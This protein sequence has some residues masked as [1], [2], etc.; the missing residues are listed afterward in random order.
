MMTPPRLLALVLAA[1]RAAPP[2]ICFHNQHKS[3]GVTF[4]TAAWNT[5]TLASGLSRSAW[6]FERGRWECEWR[7]WNASSKACEYSLWLATQRKRARPEIAPTV[8]YGGFAPGAAELR[9]FARDRCVWL[10]VFR[11]PLARLVSSLHYCRHKRFD[12]LCAS[13]DLEPRNATL[14]EWAA[15][16]G[17]YA[18]RGV[19]LYP[20]LARRALPA[21][22]ATVARPLDSPFRNRNSVWLENKRAMAGGD[23]PA[24]ARG[25]ANL[26]AAKKLL[27]EGA[28]YDAVGVLERL[29]ATCEL[30]D[31]AAPLVEPW[32]D[33]LARATEDHGSAAWRELERA[34]LEQAKDDAV[35]RAAIAGD[36]ELYHD[37]VVP[38]FEEMHRRAVGALSRARRRRF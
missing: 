5:P 31:A 14:R 2:Y 28:L 16:W 18:L 27:R 15:H 13:A 26:D 30:F 1:A 33:A 11:E 23:D 37:A 10:T 22:L 4:S 36:L 7:Q 29:N 34:E 20:P 17:N 32:R 38:L 8:L 3:A 9:A 35:V 19:L 12:P 24:T 21:T 6:K 25:R